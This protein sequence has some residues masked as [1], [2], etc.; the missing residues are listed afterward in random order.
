MAICSTW[1]TNLIQV[2]CVHDGTWLQQFRQRQHM[3]FNISH[4]ELTLLHSL[5]QHT[6]SWSELTT[7]ICYLFHTHYIHCNISW[8]FQLMKHLINL[9]KLGILGEIS[10]HLPPAI[11]PQ[12]YQSIY[13]IVIA[14]WFN[15]NGI[16]WKHVCVGQFLI[17]SGQR[18]MFLI[19]YLLT[20]I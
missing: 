14:V 16:P 9:M 3:E 12:G 13:V 1:K 4:G 7:K 2:T 6:A 17:G 10:I 18:D 5:L 11:S 20:Y 8:N 15:T 19:C